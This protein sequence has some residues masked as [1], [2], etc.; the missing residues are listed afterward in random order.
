MKKI[1]LVLCFLLLLCGC[2]KTGPEYLVS[3]IGF[4]GDGGKYSVSFETI[5]IN[6]E[7]TEQTLKVLKGEG[8]T[9]QQ[10]VK[11][12]D[13]Q[14]TQPLLLAHCGVI[15]IGD[16]IS[17]EQ[18]SNIKKYCYDRD[19]ITLSA[20]FIKSKNAGKLL[21]AKPL[22]SACVGY[23]IMGLIKQNKHFKNRFFEVLSSDYNAVLP[24]IELGNGGLY[25]EGVK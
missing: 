7:N 21:S 23:D 13:R 1:F 6:S 22:S 2:E 16:G 18:F 11:E 19:P 8:E 25:F 10:A 15:I 12:I 9:I 20:F 17:S 5:I 14:C 4:D 3:S 24:R